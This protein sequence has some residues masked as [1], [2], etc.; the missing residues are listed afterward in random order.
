M[1]NDSKTP[2]KVFLYSSQV[3]YCW[4]FHEPLVSI[5]FPLYSRYFNY[6]LNTKA[7]L[8]KLCKPYK[9]FF[10]V[11]KYTRIF[12]LFLSLWKIVA[13]LF[14]WI[15][16]T[17]LNAFMKALHKVYKRFSWKTHSQ[18]MMMK[19]FWWCRTFNHVLMKNFK[20]EFIKKFWRRRRIFEMKIKT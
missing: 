12:L 8:T 1:K 15:P 9:N 10:Q 6:S 7:L 19:S 5:C 20:F 3:L 18:L 17:E 16:L 2:P 13:V 4:T 11:M 14:Q